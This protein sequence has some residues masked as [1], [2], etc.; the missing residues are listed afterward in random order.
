M[1]RRPL[2]V[3][4]L[5]MA[6]LVAASPAMASPRA[7]VHGSKPAWARSAREHARVGAHQR[8]DFAIYLRMRHARAARAL[9]LAVSTPGSSRYG[10]YLG[11]RAYAHRF[12]PTRATARAVVRWLRSRG[13]RVTGVS[14]NRSYVAAS[15]RARAVERAFHTRLALYRYK[16]HLRRAVSRPVSLPRSIARHVLFVGGLSQLVRMRTSTPQPI[17]GY[18]QPGPCSSYWGQKIATAYPAAYGRKQPWGPC[19]YTPPQLRSAYGIG[20]YSSSSNGAGVTVASTLWYDSPTWKRDV[21]TYSHRHGVP[22]FAPGQAMDI[23]PQRF[24]TRQFAAACGGYPYDE[25]SLDV[26]AIHGMA[27]AA[28]FVY[29]GANSCYDSDLLVALHRIVDADRAQIISNSWGSLGEVVPEQFTNAYTELF[30]QAALK[31]I[32][33]YFSSGDYGD[34]LIFGDRQPD[35][36]ANNP[37][38]TAVGGTSL[39]IGKKWNYLFE[40]GWGTERSTFEN[41]AWTPTP[42]GDFWAGGGGGTSRVFPEPW[43]QKPVVPRSLSHYFGANGIPTGG[44]VV[45]DVAMVGD[46]YTG[47]EIGFTQTFP[48]GVYYSEYSIGGTSLSVPLFAGVM[49]I[50]DQKAGMRHGFANPALYRIAGTSAYHDIVNPPHPVAVVARSYANGLNAAGGYHVRLASFNRTGTLHTRPGYDDV[51][52]MGTPRGAAFFERL[53]AAG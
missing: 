25:Q 37:F 53:N 14:P 20:H 30:V 9:A 10:H 24:R 38:V 34:N 47:M 48:N 15:G 13:L 33:V 3:A 43:Y 28:K 40:T 2:V 45:P 12:G 19:G 17:P 26:E 8:I 4:A 22:A 46:P 32:G 7:V 29:S 42:P 18:R 52:G 31:G 44:R 11:N 41:G 27:P 23:T 5:A 21:N 35:A 51:T 50:A 36:P 39:A 1:F 6:G 49:A 16:G